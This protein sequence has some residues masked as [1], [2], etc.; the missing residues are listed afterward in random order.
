MSIYADIKNSNDEEEERFLKDLSK[1][2][3][4]E[5]EDT[6]SFWDWWDGLDDIERE[7]YNRLWEE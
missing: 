4:E 7:E 6:E 2:E 1:H 5:M 3:T